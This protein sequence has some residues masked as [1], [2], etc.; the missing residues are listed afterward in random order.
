MDMEGRL[1][2][3]PTNLLQTESIKDWCEKLKEHAEISEFEIETKTREEYL[4]V[5]DHSLLPTIL[6][7]SALLHSYI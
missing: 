7:K 5:F 2:K 6:P 3:L 1:S 4:H